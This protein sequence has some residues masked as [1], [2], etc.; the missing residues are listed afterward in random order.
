MQSREQSFFFQ[1]VWSIYDH[2]S[3]ANDLPISLKRDECGQ[4]AEADTLPE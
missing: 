1:R 3:Q 4:R 2:K